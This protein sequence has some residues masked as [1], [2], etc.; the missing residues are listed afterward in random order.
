[1]DLTYKSEEKGI[2]DKKT[3]FYTIKKTFF[4]TI[5]KTYERER[6]EEKTDKMEFCRSNCFS[7]DSLTKG[8][9]F[10]RVTQLTPSRK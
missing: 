3:F 2:L 4:Y 5:K 10:I 7:M 6:E 9:R 1:M 8:S